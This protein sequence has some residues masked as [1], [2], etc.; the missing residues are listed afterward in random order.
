MKNAWTR[1]LAWMLGLTM[2]VAAPA[3]AETANDAA[4]ELQVHVYFDSNN[5]GERGTYERPVPGADVSVVMADGET[6][7]GPVTT[8]KDG[9]ATLEDIPAGEYRVRVTLPEGW[10]Y[11][12]KGTK[13]RAG[14]SSIMD[15]ASGPEQIS[16]PVEL[17]PGS[18]TLVGVGALKMSAVSGK[19]W[20]DENDDGIMQADEPGCAGTKIELIGERNGL[21]YETVSSADGLYRIDQVKPGLYKLQVTVSEGTMFTRYSKKGGANRSF[22]TNDGKRTDARQVTLEAGEE[23]T[24][25]HVGLVSDGVLTMACFL[26]A[27]YNGLWDEG[28]APL[29]GVTC[30]AIKAN[31]K[32]AASAVSDENGRVTLA[33]LRTGEYRIRAL[34]PKGY[35]FT[36]VSGEEAGNHFAA[37]EGRREN[38][39]T[40]VTVTAGQVNALAVGAVMPGAISGVAYL[41]DDFSAMMEKK[42]Q[43]VSGLKVE[44]YNAQGELVA[45]DRTNGKGRYEFAELNPGTYQ[46]RTTAKAGYAFTR[47]GEG[48]VV[49]NTGSGEGQTDWI[50]LALGQE[51]TH[52]DMGMIRPG[53]VEGSVFADINDNGLWDEN[54]TGLEG[55]AVRLM[56]EFGEVFSATVGEDGAFC[57]DAVMPGRYYLRYELPERGAFARKAAKGNQIEGEDGAGAGQW[58]DFK[59]GSQ[60]EAPL[61]GGL[62]LGRITAT[63]FRDSNGNGAMDGGESPLNGV[64]LQLVPSRDD[65]ETVT[66]TTGADGALTIDG[67][68]P[69]TYTATVIC[70]ETYVLSR[71]DGNAL[72]FHAGVPEAVELMVPM[73]GL[74]AD[75]PLGCVVPA[76]IHGVAWL[77][78]DNDGHHDENEKAPAGRTVEVVDQQS[79]EIFAE[80]VIGEDGVFEAEGLIPGL[81]MLRYHSVT[82]QTGDCTFIPAGTSAMMQ[83]EVRL[84]EGGKAT[85]MKAAVVLYTALEGHAWVDMGDGVA[86]LPGVELSL[87]DASGAVVQT[88]F[89]GEAGEYRFGD[90]LPGQYTVRAELP[91]GHVAVEPGDARLA[92]DSRISIMSICQGRSAQSAVLEV[93]MGEDQQNLDIGAVLPGTL[94]DYCW[95]DENENGLQDS[96]EHG[97]SGV[98]LELTRDGRVVA[99]T[100]SDAY[101]YY[102]FAEVYPA[103]YV[104]RVTPPEGLKPT[105]LR[106]DIP[107]VASVLEATDSGMLAAVTVQSDK[108]NRNADLGFV[109]TTAGKYPAGYGEAA[110]QDWTKPD[111]GE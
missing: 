60:V 22:F 45:Q 2:A 66:V 10:G 55:T 31:G 16:Q 33:A 9:E 58:F 20:L 86:P 27:N 36:L 81:Y 96:S 77:D 71:M 57:F 74:W 103:E 53:T 1:T 92:D 40:G 64:T 90:L 28:E 41:D 52:M 85:G 108:N 83:Q 37:R 87:L 89:T 61:C 102:R 101:G 24:E 43:I 42:E 75:Q 56:D 68:H 73:G 76:S 67:L 35:A 49:V 19:V 13:D 6:A 109:L 32:T 29:P 95:L 104:I 4:A 34:L 78:E 23:L 30:E 107:V 51:L 7:V 110:G 105:Q 59:T 62:I 14:S 79:G 5:N 63:A 50:E 82:P 3:I 65:L 46:V 80:M 39:L 8:D 48:N 38:T 12:K 21:T 54:E 70:P 26:D 88:T 72:P 93:R 91:E 25:R 47:L 94:G 84:E 111:W 98:K 100:T 18:Q 17:L 97:I 44:L 106:T 69:D 15:A 11:G 99:E